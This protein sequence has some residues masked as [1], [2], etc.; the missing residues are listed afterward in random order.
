MTSVRLRRICRHT[1]LCLLLFLP[2]AWALP[3]GLFYYQVKHQLLPVLSVKLA[4]VHAFSLSGSSGN[5]RLMASINRDLQHSHY[6][7]P[8]TVLG[9]CQLRLVDLYGEKELASGWFSGVLAFNWYHGLDKQTAYLQMSCSGNWLVLGLSQL[10]LALSTAFVFALLPVPLGS[11]A[12]Q[13]QK[14]F[15]QDGADEKTALQLAIAIEALNRH[16]Q[17][18]FKLMSGLSDESPLQLLDKIKNVDIAPLSDSQWQWFE[19]GYMHTQSLSQALSIAQCED[20]VRFYS[21]EHKVVIHGLEC[22][23]PQTPFYYYQ[24]YAALKLADGEGWYINP[25]ADRPDPVAA[26]QLVVLMQNHAGHGKAIN[27]LQRQGLRSKVLDQ[28]RNKLKDKLHEI[29]GETLAAGYLFNV[30]RDQKSGRHQYQ[31][32][33]PDDK[34]RIISQ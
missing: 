5:E 7:S 18:A 19:R 17:K 9:E 13:W 12:R 15:V 25:A 20:D 16:Q 21:D 24:W 8:L 26:G 14:R 10:F 27:D 2:L 32:A 30:R 23:L 11:L 22:R 31:L 3:K 6:A 1:F 29:L 34:L 28:N 33:V 4:D